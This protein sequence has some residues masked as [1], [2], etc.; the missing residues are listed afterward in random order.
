MPQPPVHDDVYARLR[1]QVS[2]FDFDEAVAQV[3]PDMIARSVPGYGLTL[4][5]IGL[6]A[7]RYAQP[8]TVCYDLG[9][10]LGGVTLAL[11]HHIDQPGCRITAV[12]NAPAMIAR[13]RQILAEDDSDVPVDVVEADIRD[14]PIH[15]A[16]VVVLHFTLQFL[17]LIERDHLIRRIYAGLHAGGVLILSEKV[18]FADAAQ[19]ARFITLHHDFKRANGYSDL[20]ISQKRTAL[21]N[22]LIPET[23]AQHQRR[24]QI[25]GFTSAEVWFQAFNFVSLLAVK[26]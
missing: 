24:L 25:A 17:D 2:P 20:E 13:L 18:I 21:E 3:F 1:T 19:N 12:D 26:E 6:I 22:V 4:P 10:S 7:R 14:I 23:I 15:N 8:D 16:S 5:L 9:C 11:R